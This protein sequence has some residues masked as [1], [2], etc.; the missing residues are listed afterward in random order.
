MNR[1]IILGLLLIVV[2][3]MPV[4]AQNGVLKLHINEMN[5]Y[6]WDFD[7][8]NVDAVKFLPW[9]I[10]AQAA[11]TDAVVPSSLRNNR[12]FLESVRLTNLAQVAFED[13]DYEA[14]ARYSADA[15]RYAQMSDDFVS[16]QLKIR[17]TD[18]AIV[19]ANSRLYWANSPSVNAAARYPN[20]LSLAQ[21]AYS[22]ARTLR[23]SE[24]WDPALRAAHRV[25]DILANLTEIG[26]PA[27]VASTPPAS[28]TTTPATTA[29]ATSTPSTPPASTTTT[30]TTTTPAASTPVATPSAPPATTTPSAYP[31][32][33][34]YTV[35][36]WNSVKDCF[37][38]IA[39]LPSVYNDPWQWRRL[40]NANKT[41]IPDPNN[42]DIIDP[43][44]ILDIPS[45][46]GEVREGMWVEGRNYVPLR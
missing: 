9:A 24:N 6:L 2:L 29:P 37:W 33:A 16:L 7:S 1:K 32:P 17:E 13:G 4:F 8:I 41:K 10:L 22:E 31:L 21:A 35:R 45:I 36:T 18:N 44:T 5:N 34:Q 15:I 30:P 14:S 46:R 3:G 19:L 38:N 23:T 20:E 27:T 25:I 39:G 40:Y 42:P 28:T 26:A 12:Y 43:G 11:T